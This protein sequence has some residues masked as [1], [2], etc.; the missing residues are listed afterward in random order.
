[1]KVGRKLS[2]GK[3]SSLRHCSQNFRDSK[4]RAKVWRQNR[5]FSSVGRATD[6]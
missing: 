2:A 3:N 1:L 5:A 6:F 4:F